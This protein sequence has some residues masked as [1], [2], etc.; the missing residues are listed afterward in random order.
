MSYA[1]GLSNRC[2]Q[3]KLEILRDQ[4]PIHIKTKNSLPLWTFS[5]KVNDY[6]G[7]SNDFIQV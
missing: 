1:P 2:E 5:N 4:R 3:I 7:E 6:S